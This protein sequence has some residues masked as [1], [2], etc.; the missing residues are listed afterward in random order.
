MAKQT[1]VEETSAG[2]VGFRRSDD[3]LLVL[4]IRDAYKNWGFPKGHVEPG[5]DAAR[6]ALRRALPRGRARLVACASGAQVE[7]ALRAWLADAVVV[8]ARGHEAR[9]VLARCRAAYPNV[10]RFVYSA[11]R[12]DDGELLRSCIAEGDA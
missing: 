11:F 3:G 7:R 6:A 9:A 5:D 1:P 10:P 2:G 8:D 12:P 4:V